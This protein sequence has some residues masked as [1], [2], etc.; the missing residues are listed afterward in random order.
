MVYPAIK[1][2]WILGFTTAVWSSDLRLA[3]VLAC[4][5]LGGRILVGFDNNHGVEVPAGEVRELVKRALLKRYEKLAD[6]D[7]E[8]LEDPLRCICYKVDSV[9]WPSDSE[10]MHSWLDR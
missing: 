7:R 6:G 1:G 9:M 5:D 2:D 10:E 3:G 4:N 8:F